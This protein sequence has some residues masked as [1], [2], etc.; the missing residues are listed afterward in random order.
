ML[1]DLNDPVHARGI[2]QYPKH[3]CD[4]Q[5]TLVHASHV[6]HVL[7]ARLRGPDGAG[8]M[9]TKH[10]RLGN[11]QTELSMED[12][13]TRRNSE[14]LTHKSSSSKRSEP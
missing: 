2:L 4:L 8:I 1:A 13:L 5:V 7:N 10:W 9:N 3:F 6:R 12:R 14:A 11:G